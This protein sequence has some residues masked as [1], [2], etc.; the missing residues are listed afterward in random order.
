MR[1]H[2]SLG[3][4]Q[5][6]LERLLAA[7]GYE[8]VL[9][10]YLG[11]V[12]SGHL[13]LLIDKPGG[14]T[15]ADCEGVSRQISAY[16]DVVDPIPSGYTLEVSSPG[17]NRPLTKDE[18]LEANLGQRVALRLSTKEGGSRRMEGILKRVGKEDLEMEV[19]GH[20]LSIPREKI[21]ESRLKYDWDQAQHASR[22][23][24]APGARG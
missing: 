7:W 22:K 3:A 2:T 4:L 12:R 17:V 21:Q 11:R 1:P 8:L 5:G 9:L 19:K 23:P 6:E 14:V 18:H 24:E 13:E 20:Y 10:R 15:L 16:L